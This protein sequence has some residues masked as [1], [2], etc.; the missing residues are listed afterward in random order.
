MDFSIIWAYVPVVIRELIQHKFKV[1]MCFSVVSL[2]VLVVGMSTPSTFKT[3]GTI[4]ADNQN[5]LK[6]ILAQKA[7]VTQIQ[8][9]LRVVR[10]TIFA[11][12]FLRQVVESV[13]GTTDVMTAEEIDRYANG[14]KK[15]LDISGIGKSSNYMIVNYSDSSPDKAFDVINAVI[16]L[17]IR[18][19]SE[20]RRSDTKEAFQFIDSQVRQYKNQLLAAEEQL[21]QF[22]AVNFDGREA[23][24][25]GRIGGL[26]AALEEMKINIDEAR[27][28][29]EALSAQ[30][31][32][33]N[34]QA[35]RQ[36]KSDVFRGRLAELQG[37]IDTLLLTY[38]ESYPDVVNLR[39]QMKD[40]RA[41]MN[42]ALEEEGS[43][44][45]PMSDIT[46]NPFYEQ[47]RAKLSEAEVGLNSQLRRKAAT[48]RLL[49]EEFDRRKRIAA[50]Q[51]EL[52]ELT[53]DYN[54]TQNIYED[55][56]GRKEKARL[57][58]TLSIEGQGVNYKIQEPAEYPLK[59]IGIRFIHFVMIGPII[60]LLI[61]LAAAIGYVLLDQ[62]VRF[63]T[64]LPQITS[65]PLLVV[66]PRFRTPFA[67]RIARSDMVLLG[68]LFISM[69]AVYGGIAAGHRAGMF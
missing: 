49:G 42:E 50:Q 18:Q 37:R 3:S 12:S 4:Y 38:Q 54:V 56:L 21:K 25:D 26:R 65:V 55:M 40:I 10:E 35:A 47:L 61:P 8:E 68:F 69:L 23:D 31:K 30:L 63:P 62:R 24:V 13:Y 6:P 2:A 20:M 59:P 33:E 19:S 11:P 39:L 22:K 46:S 15:K 43:S 9:Q 45:Q 14:I 41:A 52:S 29:V 57:S 16:D 67:K 5:I 28:R 34:R 53:R 17:F 7:A 1:L 64:Q 51:A 66:I 44:D 36:Y 48:E 32:K 27:S 60:G 58:M